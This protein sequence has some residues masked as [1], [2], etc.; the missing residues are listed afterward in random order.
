MK[1]L[2]V[3]LLVLGLVAAATA[4]VM[5]FMAMNV[6][7]KVIWEIAT[8]YSTDT[9]LRDPRPNLLIISGIVL[10]AGLLLGLGLGLPG[11]L[12]PSQKKLDDLVETRVEE[13]L[14]GASDPGPTT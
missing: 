9:D 1:V 12:S 3:I 13:R 5:L 7:L 4:G 8:R 11:R 6:E 14:R 2:K 10:G